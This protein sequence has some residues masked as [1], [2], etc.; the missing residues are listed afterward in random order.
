MGSDAAR[1][2]RCCAGL[3]LRSPLADGGARACAPCPR[4]FI[5]K[6]KRVKL[7]VVKDWCRQILSGLAFLHERQI[8]HRDL[9]CDN[10]FINGNTGEVKIGDLGLSTRTEKQANAESVI[11]ACA[12]GRAQPRLEL[13]LT[14][15][16]LRGREVR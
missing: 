2:S 12:A 16:G 9:K 10:I 3:S 4:R 7:K 13:R 11:G 5:N 1:G 15:C 14:R 6:H 8:I